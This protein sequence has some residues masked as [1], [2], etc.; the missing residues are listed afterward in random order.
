MLDKSDVLSYLKEFKKNNAKKYYIDKIGIFG[1]LA[2]D[3]ASSDSDIDIVVDMIKPNLLTL[4]TIREE[5]MRYFKKDVDIVAL[6]D[7]M[8]PRLKKR[9]EK[10]AIYV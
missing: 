5:I 4:S 10:E 2:R 6:W 8:N 9:I 7:K 1:S 3:E